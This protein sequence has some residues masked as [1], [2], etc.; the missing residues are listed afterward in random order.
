[1]SQAP[2]RPA[3]G[4]AVGGVE[5]SAGFASAADDRSATGWHLGATLFECRLQEAPVDVHKAQGIPN[6]PGTG[7]GRPYS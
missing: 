5:P 1:M 2:H 3:V 6:M 7:L 4:L